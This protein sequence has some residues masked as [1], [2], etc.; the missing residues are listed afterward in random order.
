M[1]MYYI[2]VNCREEREFF[3][4]PLN[5]I[6]MHQTIE[7]LLLPILNKKNKPIIF[8][9]LYIS[10]FEHFLHQLL[11]DYMDQLYMELIV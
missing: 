1:Y 6:M 7:V 3:F 11:V 4:S 9:L 8:F 5:N 2:N 10:Y